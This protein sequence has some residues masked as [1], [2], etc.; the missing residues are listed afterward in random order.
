[1]P[2][3]S[4]TWPFPTSR[5]S[6][7]G[8]PL[9]GRPTWRWTPR[10]GR[11]RVRRMAA[12]KGFHEVYEAGPCLARGTWRT[13]HGSGVLCCT[14]GASRAG[15]ACP[16]EWHTGGVTGLGPPTQALMSCHVW[17]AFWR[18]RPRRACWAA[19]CAWGCCG[20]ALGGCRWAAAGA[21]VHAR[22]GTRE[23]PAQQNG[24]G[25]RGLRLWPSQRAEDL[26]AR[27]CEEAVIGVLAALGL[28]T[29]LREGPHSAECL[30]YLR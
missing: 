11:P 28:Q 2:R 26:W 14:L 29:T 21:L 25:L 20:S 4:A 8:T 1:M 16:C 19:S 13:A 15:A 30:Q 5:P 24:L 12:E 22:A 9:T 7:T 17:Q 27:A 23:V 18:R 10:C 3:P 6:T